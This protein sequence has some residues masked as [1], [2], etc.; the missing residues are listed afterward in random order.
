M[1]DKAPI[2]N[3]VA[4]IMAG[5]SGTRF[6][7]LSLKKLPKQYL[8]LTGSRSLIQETVDRIRSLCQVSDIYIASGNS[9]EDL[10]K[11]QL[12]DIPNRILEPASKN[13]AACLM[14]ATREL[15]KKGYSPNTPIMVFPADHVIG[16]PGLFF[17]L[18]R[19]AL[20][21]V[22][23]RESLVTF[24]ITPVTPHTGYGYIEAGALE[25]HAIHQVTRFTEKPDKTTAENFLRRGN[26]FWNS[27]IFVW[28]LRSICHAFE[29]FCSKSWSQMMQA[30]SPISLAA[31][32]E[33]LPSVPI[34]TAVL[35]KSRNVFVIPA[36]GLG[37]S[38]VGS[39]S[40]LHQLKAAHSHDNVFLGGDIRA[41]ESQGCLAKVPENIQVALVGLKD[42]I[43]IFNGSTLLI[44][45]KGQ[46]QKVK[47]ASQ[48]FED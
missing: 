1:G 41:L 12:P 30:E 7:P 33:T 20:S 15:L 23:E 48:L 42:L 26:Y 39:W 10:L 24:G 16:N 29:E 6:W 45:D 3:P 22:T 21:F 40:A 43:V 19:N 9:Q 31:V 46:D 37:W 27:G 34:D 14:L 36:Q 2:L 38:D 13:T 44:A 35:E 5:G 18:L 32:F 11:Q 47:E 4:L 8:S 17:S 28:T 25:T